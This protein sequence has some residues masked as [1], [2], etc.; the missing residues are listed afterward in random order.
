M[1]HPNPQQLH[2]FI[3]GELSVRR[4]R[5]IASH[6][7]GCSECA[8]VVERTNATGDLLRLAADEIIAEAPLEGFADQVMARLAAEEAPL[9]WTERIRAWVSEFI[10]YQRKVWVPPMAV[11]AAA[12]VAAVL[13]FGFRGSPVT[14]SMGT[15]ELPQGTTV[16]SVSFGSSVDGTVFEVEDKDGSITAVIWVDRAK[17]MSE[18]N[19]GACRDVPIGAK[20]VKW[21]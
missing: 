14:D 12:A 19:T 17:S 3:D 20:G 15:A 9:P 7:E 4:T 5:K 8:E 6:L 1:G 21:T 2:R 10:L 16:L 13:V 18:E 11:A